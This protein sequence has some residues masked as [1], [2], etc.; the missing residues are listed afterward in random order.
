ME[1]F[2]TR[3]AIFFKNIEY[4]TK[5]SVKDL[6]LREAWLRNLPYEILDKSQTGQIQLPRISNRFE[7]LSKIIEDRCSLSRF[8]DGELNLTKNISI[9]FQTASLERQARYCCRSSVD[10]R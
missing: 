5:Y 7:T 10:R 6:A 2:K 3:L 1:K 9:P 4:L 8:G